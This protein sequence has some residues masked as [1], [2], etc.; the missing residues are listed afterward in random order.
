MFSPKS[1]SRPMCPS[2]VHSSFE[3]KSSAHSETDAAMTLDDGGYDGDCV[4]NSRECLCYSC[5]SGGH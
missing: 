5:D 2:D 3:V 4:T 1:Y